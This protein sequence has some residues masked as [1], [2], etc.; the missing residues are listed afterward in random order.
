VQRD[1][2]EGISLNTIKRRRRAEV[3]GPPNVSGAY[4]TTVEAAAYLKL[5]RQYLEGARHRGDGSGPPYV[6]LARA[7]RYRKTT[8]DKWMASHNHAANAPL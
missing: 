2:N 8:L 1:I 4:L 6:K 5:S 3:E 7:V